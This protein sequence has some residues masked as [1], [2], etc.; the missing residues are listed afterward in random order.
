M[1]DLPKEADIVVRVGG[2]NNPDIE[3]YIRAGAKGIIAANVESADEASGFVKRVKN[4]N[5]DAATV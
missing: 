3:E 1:K 5:P 2:C 4:S